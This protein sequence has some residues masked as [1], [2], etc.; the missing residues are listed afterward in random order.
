MAEGEQAQ[1]RRGLHNVS[2]QRG[3]YTFI[4]TVECTDNVVYQVESRLWD[5][6]QW[7]DHVGL[8]TVENQGKM[9]KE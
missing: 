5:S 9:T 7:M 1:G 8:V 3:T 6:L 4:I 2:P